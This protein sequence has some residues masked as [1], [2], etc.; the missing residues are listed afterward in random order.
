M[1]SKDRKRGNRGVSVKTVALVESER[2]RNGGMR[3]RLRAVKLLPGCSI[4]GAC[5][6]T[7]VQAQC[8]CT[9]CHPFYFVSIALVDDKKQLGMK[10]C[11]I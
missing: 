2:G 3:R 9:E 6:Y 4:V 1:L 8:E 5:C 11:L 10:K 7:F